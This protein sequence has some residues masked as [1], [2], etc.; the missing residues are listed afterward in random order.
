MRNQSG[1]DIAIGFVTG[2]K[3]F[4][5]LVTTYA[6]RWRTIVAENN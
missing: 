3:G 2:R 4:R 6:F 1:T 5:K